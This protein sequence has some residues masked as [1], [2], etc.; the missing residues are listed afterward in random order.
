MQGPVPS[1][2]AG[3][4]DQ[5]ASGGCG[6]GYMALRPESCLTR[7]LAM[8]EDALSFPPHQQLVLTTPVT[9]P[10]PPLPRVQPSGPE[11]ASSLTGP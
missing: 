3:A 10:S 9:L 11:S 1:R 6:P 2:E 5:L 8:W 4:E 7:A